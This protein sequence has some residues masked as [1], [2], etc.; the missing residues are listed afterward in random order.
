M[1]NTNSFLD[2]LLG[3]A[4]DEFVGCLFGLVG[5]FAAVCSA[6]FLVPHPVPSCILPMYFLS[7]KKKLKKT[8]F[9][10]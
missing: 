9:S 7:I 1:A 8:S 5:F 2:F 4:V 3:W 10:F 6:V